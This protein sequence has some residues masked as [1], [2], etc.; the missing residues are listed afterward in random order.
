MTCVAEQ[1]NESKNYKENVLKFNIDENLHAL[2]VASNTPIA[3]FLLIKLQLTVLCIILAVI[4][5]LI[6]ILC[7]IN[8][9]KYKHKLQSERAIIKKFDLSSFVNKYN[10]HNDANNAYNLNSD[11]GYTNGAFINNTED[12]KMNKILSP[13][14]P[15]TNLYSYESSNP[16]WLKKY[17]KKEIIFNTKLWI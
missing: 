17:D 10:S 12:N 2:S 7:F 5:V 13:Y 14:I 1:F 4:L 9:R 6:L 16:V 8:R 3:Q 15:G 11:F